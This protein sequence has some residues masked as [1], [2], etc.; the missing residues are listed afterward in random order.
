MVELLL[1]SF[2]PQGK[3]GGEQL[4]RALSLVKRHPRAALALV[5][6]LWVRQAPAIAAIR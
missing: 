2:Y 6:G 5:R 4:K 1:P 3:P